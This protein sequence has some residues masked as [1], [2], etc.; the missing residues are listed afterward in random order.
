MTI[1]VWEAFMKTLSRETFIDLSHQILIY[2]IRLLEIGDS[3]KLFVYLFTQI[4][5][6][7]TKTK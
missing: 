1:D 5:H 2:I 4:N 7:K 3:E 6:N